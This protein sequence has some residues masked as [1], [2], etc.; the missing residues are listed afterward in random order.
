M[1]KPNLSDYGLKGID[2]RPQIDIDNHPISDAERAAALEHLIIWQV[3]NVRTN[4][5]RAALRE[6]EW[7]EGGQQ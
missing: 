2:S 5:F 4:E 1:K 6:W 7:K 3:G